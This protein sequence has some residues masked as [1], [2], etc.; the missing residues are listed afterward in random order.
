MEFRG[1]SRR[2]AANVLKDFNTFVVLV[3]SVHNFPFLHSFLDDR[4]KLNFAHRTSQH[5]NLFL[6]Y[7]IIKLSV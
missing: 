7:E 3:G 4:R 5:I 2:K 1:L 6:N